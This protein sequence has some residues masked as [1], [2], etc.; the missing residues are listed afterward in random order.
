MNDVQVRAAT[1]D[2]AGV[3]ADV[4]AAPSALACPPHTTAE[5]IASFIAENLT[6]ERFTEYLADPG[7]ALVVAEQ[8]GAMVGYAMLVHGEPYDADARAVVKHLPTTEL[9]KLYVLAT[10]HGSGVARHLLT[11]T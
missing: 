1:A 2:D 9:S 7:R 11:A 10:A 6:P 4:A 5:S 8:Q 3:I